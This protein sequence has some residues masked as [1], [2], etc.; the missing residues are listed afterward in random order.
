M[1]NRE[2]PRNY[3]IEEINQNKSKCKK[4]LQGFELDWKLTYFG[5]HSY[6]LCFYFCFCSLVSIPIGIMSCA[7][8]LEIYVITA[9]IEKSVINKKKK[10]NDKIELIAKDKLNN[11][12]SLLFTD[13]TNSYISQDEFV[14]VN[15]VLREYDDM[16]E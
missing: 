8:G 16:Q 10:T 9:G 12:Q 15:K 7:I 5:C 11:T 4:R 2:E 3:F 1:K 14:L 6:W 13:L